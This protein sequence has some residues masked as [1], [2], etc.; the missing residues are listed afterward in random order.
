MH[1]NKENEMKMQKGFTLIEIMIVVAIVAILARIAIPAYT[2]YL[3][4]G[5]LVDAQSALTS[6]RV[7]MEQYYQDNRTYV[8]G[9]CPASTAYFSYTC[10]TSAT[11]YTIK[12]D[13]I[14]GVGLGAANSYEYNIDQSNTKSTA[15]FPGR[16]ASNN[17][18]I[19]K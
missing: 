5:K 6:G 1:H 17:T 3:V 9:T 11:A 15:T 16:Q 4:R 19:S 7:A 12:A 8:N 10:T 2:S 13:N 14:A 18:W